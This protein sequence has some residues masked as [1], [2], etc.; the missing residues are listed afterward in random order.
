MLVDVVQMVAVVRLG[1]SL[2]AVAG[3]TIVDVK[4]LSDVGTVAAVDVVTPLG[5]RKTSC[6][7]C[8]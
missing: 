3:W 1:S 2:T 6:C 4:S 8:C 7:C 5:L